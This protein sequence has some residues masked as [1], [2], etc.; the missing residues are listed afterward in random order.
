MADYTSNL[1][2]WFKLDEASGTT[3]VDSSSTAKNGIWQ[4]E[5]ARVS[6]ISGGA[7]SLATISGNWLTLSQTFSLAAPPWTNTY[8]A[9]STDTTH[10]GSNVQF[11]QNGVDV[12]S[13]WN[14]DKTIEIVCQP[15]TT[16]GPVVETDGT[17]HLFGAVDDG[18][19]IKL[20]LD[21]NF[22]GSVDSLGEG[23]SVDPD[24]GQTTIGTV[25]S[26]N[27][28]VMDD[29]RIWSRALTEADLTA[30]L[31]S[32]PATYPRLKPR[33][34]SANPIVSTTFATWSDYPHTL[35]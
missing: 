9:K 15:E 7:I 10:G 4:S 23:F 32:Y 5:P 18:A 34:T 28:L 14:T 30:L 8:L 13:T 29:I 6:G 35:L 22:V 12:A 25:T 26:P 17:W 1:V 33:M 16:I 21:G 31:A 11:F 24:A 27:N 20:V 3:A 2:Q 19:L